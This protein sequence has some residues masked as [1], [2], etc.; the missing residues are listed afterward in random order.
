MPVGNAPSGSQMGSKPVRLIKSS[1]LALMAH[2]TTNAR[3]SGLFLRP[4][5]EHVLLGRGTGDRANTRGRWIASSPRP[6]GTVRPV[7][8]AS[9]PPRTDPLGVG[10]TLAAWHLL[11]GDHETTV[12]TTAGWAGGWLARHKRLNRP[13]RGAARILSVAFPLAGH[14]STARSPPLGRGGRSGPD[15]KTMGAAHLKGLPTWSFA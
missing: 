15:K 2:R 14:R 7:L 9:G 11:A 10:H 1:G 3:R 13:S 4:E 6:S 5:N 8:G 12:T